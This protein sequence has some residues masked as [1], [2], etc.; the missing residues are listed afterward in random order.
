M[1]PDFTSCAASCIQVE[2]TAEAYKAYIA[3]IAEN[4]S[5]RGGESAETVETL[6]ATRD[7]YVSELA[8]CHEVTPEMFAA[9]ET[10]GR[11]KI[12][13]ELWG[14]CTEDARS[15]LLDDKHHFV[16]SNANF[17]NRD[18]RINIIP[19]TSFESTHKYLGGEVLVQFWTNCPGR[20]V[21]VVYDLT[22]QRFV[23]LK[24]KYLGRFGT[25]NGTDI[26]CLNEMLEEQSPALLLEEF[27]CV[28]L[29]DFPDW[30]N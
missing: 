20:K 11:S 10:H 12:A 2:R 5:R 27:G 13:S 23:F 6:Y 4:G 26:S 30:M 16:K 3:A 14:I 29:T 25:L 28:P 7:E 19:C 9:I 24:A 8:K 22:S 21:R 15:L 1:T 18:F 17:S